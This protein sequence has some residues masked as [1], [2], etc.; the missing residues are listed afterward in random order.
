LTLF[1]AS[2]ADWS[3]G[4]KSTPK[5]YERLPEVIKFKNYREGVAYIWYSGMIKKIKNQKLDN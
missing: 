5:T 1:H 4:S 3:T 2:A